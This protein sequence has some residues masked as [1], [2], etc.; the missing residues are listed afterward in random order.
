MRV[1]RGKW[2]LRVEM[3]NGGRKGAKWVD[4]DKVRVEIGRIGVEEGRKGQM[5]GR[6]GSK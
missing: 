4:R 1:E 3:T 2:Y 5:G 6:K